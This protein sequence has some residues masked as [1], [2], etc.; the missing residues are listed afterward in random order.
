MRKVF[1]NLEHLQYLWF[2]VEIGI[3]KIMALICLV[4]NL[5]N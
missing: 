2:S 3:L 5:L 4:G 1:E